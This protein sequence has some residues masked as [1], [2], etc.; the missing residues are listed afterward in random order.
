MQMENSSPEDPGR[1]GMLDLL[2]V[3][4]ERKWLFVAGVVAFCVAGLVISLLMPRY[5]TATAVIMK[6]APKMPGLGSLISKEL[7]VSGILK[8]MDLGGGSD[9]DNFLSVLES[10]RMAEIVLRRFDLVRHYG[11]NKMKKYYIEDLLKAFHRNTKIVENDYGNIEVAVTDSSPGMAADIANFMLLELDTITYRLAK[12]SARNSRVFFEER[13]ALIRQ[14]LDTAAQRLTE[15][16]TKNNYIDLEHQTK[17]SVE[18]LAQFEAQKMALDLEISQLQS[19][20]GSS[21]NQRIAE[22]QKQKAVIGREIGKYMAAGGGNLII[23]LKDAPA[24]SVKY[25]Y[26]LR[27][28][29]IQESLYEFVLQLFEQA[30]FS[31]SNDVPAV[32]ALEYAQPPQKKTRPKRSI[33]CIM[34]FVAGCFAMTAYITWS[35]WMSGQKRRNTPFYKKAQYLVDLLLFRNSKYNT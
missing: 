18:A 5:Y 4:V 1:P 33:V 3:L 25:G 12:E 34:F 35:K 6:P 13:L 10:R 20:Y 17:S 14:D 27:D 22:L 32:Q 9:A 19:Q 26:L 2:I 30:K 11:F 29:K 31:E 23:A 8:S 28:V 15:F 16:Q 24:K 21:G 7:P